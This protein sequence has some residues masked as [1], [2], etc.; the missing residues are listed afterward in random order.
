M[1][2]IAKVQRNMNCQETLATSKLA[3]KIRKWPMAFHTPKKDKRK[4]LE[5]VQLIWARPLHNTKT[6]TIT[7]TKLR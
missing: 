6:T 2:K 7:T 4:V 5:K 3:H 1:A